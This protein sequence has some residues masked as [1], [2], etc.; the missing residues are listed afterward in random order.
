[1]G[2]AGA[3]HPGLQQELD[4]QGPV[5]LFEISLAALTEGVV[6]AF[7][8]L[9][10]FPEVRRDLAVL[11]D[12]GLPVSEL[13]AVIN[14]HAGEFLQQVGLFDVYAGQG[15]AEGKK[16][17]ALSVTWQHPERTLNDD[18]VNQWFDQVVE[19][20]QTQCSASLRS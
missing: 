11:V 20:M 12:E 7:T 13:Q 14:H 15:I 18:E 9:S 2:Y 10:K 17:L 4:L 3:L 6:P 8:A 19:A 5:Y 1:V 16:S